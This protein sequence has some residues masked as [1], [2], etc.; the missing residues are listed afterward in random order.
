MNTM[1]LITPYVHSFFHQHLAADRGLSPNTIACYRDSLKLLLQFAAG[2]LK[3]PIDKLVVEHFSADVV[4][5][6]LNDLEITRGNSARLSG[7][8]ALRRP[9]LPHRRRPRY[10]CPNPAALPYTVSA[11]EITVPAGRTRHSHFASTGYSLILSQSL[12]AP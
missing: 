10:P 9:D 11:H 2:K 1:H 7:S 12:N 3:T 8:G 4:L 6:F 5:A